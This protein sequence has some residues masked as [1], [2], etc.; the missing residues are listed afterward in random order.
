MWFF[1]PPV[2]RSTLKLNWPP[3]VNL[4]VKYSGSQI[5]CGQV[6]PLTAKVEAILDYPEPPTRCELVD[7]WGWM[8]ITDVL[9][10]ASVAV[11]PLPRW[12]CPNEPYWPMT[13]SM[14]LTLQQ[15]SSVVA[16]TSLGLLR[17][18]RTQV[19]QGPE[20]VTINLEKSLYR[21]CY[22]YYFDF[23]NFWP[24]TQAVTKS[25]SKNVAQLT[26]RL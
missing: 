5:G 25:W 10:E 11:A 1:S 19:L 22:Y 9:A 16:L 6:R 13:V 20:L 12:C 23:T 7:F 15:P 18:R 24:I 17:S 2:G 3:S 8:G 4:R 21:P 14:T 26:G